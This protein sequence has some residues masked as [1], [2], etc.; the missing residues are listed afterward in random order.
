MSTIISPNNIGSLTYIRKIKCPRHYVL[1]PGGTPFVMEPDPRWIGRIS[2]KSAKEFGFST[3]R[4]KKNKYGQWIQ[5]FKDYWQPEINPNLAR[6]QWF[7][8][9][10]PICQQCKRCVLK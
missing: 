1:K 8:P 2:E 9:G 6:E 3:M 10:H 4:R 5:N 7:S